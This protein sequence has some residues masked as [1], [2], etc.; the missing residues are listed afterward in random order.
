MC[1]LPVCTL[2]EECSLARS[3]RLPPADKRKVVEGL[4]SVLADK[5]KVVDHVRF[6]PADKRK[7]VEGL[8]SVLADK[9]KVVDH[10]R[11]APADENRD[12]SGQGPA[13]ESRHDAVF[14]AARQARDA[15]DDDEPGELVKTVRSSRPDVLK[16]AS[17]C[18]APFGRPGPSAPPVDRAYYRR[19]SDSGECEG[20][21]RSGG[22]L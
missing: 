4:R 16:G 1:S 14:G 12:E 22:L 20:W 13:R 11:F 9:R 3:A 18:L 5:R 6:A 17:L 19:S 15:D 7:V 10:V 21:R 8:R 2:N